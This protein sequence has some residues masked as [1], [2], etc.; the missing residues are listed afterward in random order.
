M[1]KSDDDWLSE[2]SPKMR[3]FLQAKLDAMQAKA[4]AVSA[5]RVNH[6][7]RAGRWAVQAGLRN[8]TGRKWAVVPKRMPKDADYTVTFREHWRR[9]PL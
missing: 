2:F 9:L 3:A 7:A 1:V 5:F 4:S 8:R 6:N